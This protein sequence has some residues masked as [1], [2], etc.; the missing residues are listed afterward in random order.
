MEQVAEQEYRNQ[1]GSLDRSGTA[2]D[3]TRCFWIVAKLATIS[4]RDNSS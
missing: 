4:P 2:S 3:N 1:T